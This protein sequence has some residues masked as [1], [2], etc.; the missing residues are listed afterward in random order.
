MSTTSAAATVW[1]LDWLAC[2][3]KCVCVGTWPS[4]LVEPKLA[5]MFGLL[6]GAYV[7]E[8]ASVVLERR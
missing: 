1:P 6:V 3:L 2:R 4:N 8:W 7:S 5:E